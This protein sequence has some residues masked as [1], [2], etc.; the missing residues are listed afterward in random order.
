ML[1]TRDNSNTQLSSVL[2][3]LEIKCINKVALKLFNDFQK[4]SFDRFPEDLQRKIIEKSENE[5]KA[6]SIKRG[7]ERFFS[8]REKSSKRHLRSRSDLGTSS[9]ANPLEEKALSEYQKRNHQRQ[10]ESLYKQVDAQLAQILVELGIKEFP[11]SLSQKIDKL[12]ISWFSIGDEVSTT[13]I[14]DNL[15]RAIRNVIVATAIDPDL[16]NLEQKLL[17][18]GTESADSRAKRRATMPVSLEDL[19]F[20]NAI[21]DETI[22]SDES[23]TTTTTTTNT[24]QTTTTTTTTMTPLM[25]A[26]VNPAPTATTATLPSIPK[27]NVSEQQSNDS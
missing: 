5:L 4:Q 7:K 26:G 17:K 13:V 24:K 20:L 27:S 18:L 23:T 21:L 3:Q 16:L 6:M 2:I 10:L 15:L 19:E 8:I 12:K 1:L 14:I 22:N 11:I 9:T 25:T